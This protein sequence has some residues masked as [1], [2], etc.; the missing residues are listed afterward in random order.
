M[1]SFS[2]D[3]IVNPPWTTMTDPIGVAVSS[4]SQG[5]IDLGSFSLPPNYFTRGYIK[6]FTVVPEDYRVGN[7][8]V[9]YKFTI[10]PTGEVWKLSYFEI[11][12]PEEV[13]IWDEDDLERKCD[14]N[15]QGFDWNSRQINCKVWENK[16]K[17]YSAF[18]F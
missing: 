14:Y 18:R 2:V 10:Q 15:V 4:G 8:P 11:T 9:K 5:A 7:F 13:E 17:I 16:I 6:K 1:F 3:S 12:I